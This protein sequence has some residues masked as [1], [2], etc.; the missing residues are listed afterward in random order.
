MIGRALEPIV[1]DVARDAL[2][3]VIDVRHFT[4]DQLEDAASTLVLELAA[5]GF[6]V[7]PKVD[8]DR[9]I[10]LSSRRRG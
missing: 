8:Y 10:I 3:E 1:R 4:N 2:R 5:R 9:L 7:I 6:S